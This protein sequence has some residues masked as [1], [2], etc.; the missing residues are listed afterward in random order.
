MKLINL[1]KSVLISVIYIFMWGAGSVASAAIIDF[2][3]GT[4]YLNGGG[5]VGTTNN[6]AVYS[7]VDY[8]IENGFKLDFIGGYGI[9]GN[10]YGNINGVSNDV[11]HGHWSTG[12]YG[13]LT[14]IEV[15]KVD[16]TTFDLNYFELTSNTD[17]GG[18]VASGN[19]KTYVTG[20]D[21]NGVATGSPILLPSDNWG[22]SGTN[23]Q[24]YL[25]SE[26][27]SIKKF[28]FTVG[29]R[30]DCFGMD[31]FYIDEPAP[32]SNNKVPEPSTLLLL[33]AGLTGFGLLRKR[34]KA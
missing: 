15:S 18:W 28:S 11:I 32:P 22:W 3:G 14:A 16:G 24:V 10:Y 29:D 8:Y 31:M 5:T 30:V 25:G 26:F 34:F 7:N 27:D 1:M 13:T 33:G 2:T 21:S 19:E 17:W 23:P 9:I 4:A 20:Y 6:G 12:N